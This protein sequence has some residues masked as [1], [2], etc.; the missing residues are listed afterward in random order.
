M[1][2]TPANATGN[3]YHNCFTA[4]CQPSFLT[5]LTYLS[6]YLGYSKDDVFEKT[7]KLD[8]ARSSFENYNQYDFIVVGAG[9]AGCVVA[10]RLSEIRK[11]KVRIVFSDRVTRT[12][13]PR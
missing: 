6:Q 5:L 4:S 11:W 10:N 3:C 1:T 8:E 12:V 2:W 13:F 7:K 9:S